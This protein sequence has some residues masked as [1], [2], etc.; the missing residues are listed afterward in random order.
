MA[1]S[2]DVPRRDEV[3]KLAK[4][5]LMGIFYGLFGAVL[6]LFGL[7][8]LEAAQSGKEYVNNGVS[9]T[10]ELL[11]YCE[12]QTGI[13]ES[14]EWD[15]QEGRCILKRSVET[16]YNFHKYEDA[17]PLQSLDYENF[18][19]VDNYDECD[20]WRQ[21]PLLTVSMSLAHTFDVSRLPSW[22]HYTTPPLAFQQTIRWACR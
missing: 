21:K 13:R 22:Q 16:F 15:L 14:V 8:Q 3:V 17:I 7:F 18:E 10:Q 20:E 1:L 5:P 2:S 19:V 9:S 6:L 12:Q 11:L 4:N